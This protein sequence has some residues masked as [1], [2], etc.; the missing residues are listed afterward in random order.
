MENVADIMTTE[1]VTLSPEDNVHQ[2]RSLLKKYNI[3]HLPIVSADGKFEGM[4]TQRD[5]L[6][7]AFT[8]VEKYGV[9]KLAHREEQLKI[10]EVMSRDAKTLPS[11]TS[12]IDAGHFFLQ[13]KHACLPIVD[14]GQ[15]QGIVTSVDFVKLSIRLLDAN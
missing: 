10:N 5:L 13:H 15:L 9:S 12:L 14:N 7:T 8:I 6:N 3:R 11:S 2:A 4:L 1:L